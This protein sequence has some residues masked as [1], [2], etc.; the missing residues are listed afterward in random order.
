MTLRKSSTPNVRP[1]SSSSAM[2]ASFSVCMCTVGVSLYRSTASHP[3]SLFT[4]L[5]NLLCPGHRLVSVNFVG[6]QANCHGHR[7]RA[8]TVGHVEAVSGARQLDVTHHR[9]GLAAQLRDEV[10]RLLNRNDRV[11]AAV[12]HQERRCTGMGAGDRR[13][14]PEDLRMPVDLPLHHDAFQEVDESGSLDGGL[15]LPVVAAVDADDRVN[16]G[17]GT[18]G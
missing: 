10:P 14:P 13:R 7:A 4:R 11:A 9:A 15:V 16:R 3:L 6:E 1:L 8:S 12:D 17:I 5:Y 18:L 2:T